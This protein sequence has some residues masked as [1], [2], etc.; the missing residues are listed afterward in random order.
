VIETVFALPGMGVLA[1]TSTRRGDIP[2]IQGVALTYTA[3]V[4]VVNLV[5]DVLYLLVNPRLRDATT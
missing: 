1:A 5:I 4:V 3:M 2:A